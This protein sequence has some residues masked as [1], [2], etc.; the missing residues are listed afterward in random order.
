MIT[1]VIECTECHDLVD[2]T[3][4]SIKLPFVCSSC[5]LEAKQIE[6]DTLKKVLASDVVRD[7]LATNGL[8][9]D[10][11]ALDFYAKMAPSS[12]AAT[13][14]TINAEP[15]EE[16]ATVENTTLL[17]E[18]LEAQVR[19]LKERNVQQANDVDLLNICLDATDHLIVAKDTQ[20][21]AMQRKNEY[22]EK[23]LAPKLRGDI[24][25][26]DT[27]IANQAGTIKN[28]EQRNDD[29]LSRNIF[30]RLAIVELARMVKF[31][32][33]EVGAAENRAG[34]EKAISSGLQS[35]VMSLQREKIDLAEK[36][37]R[38]ED[39]N[40][41]KEFGLNYWNR[42]CEGQGVALKDE[43]AKSLWQCFK[44]RYFDNLTD[45]KGEKAYGK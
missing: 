33:S 9:V 12:V 25:A 18:D 1:T 28:L 42:V 27:Q 15:T 20:I 14:A 19:D 23:T 41:R 30:Q 17:I 37:V 24:D 7:H 3:T 31:L 5:D 22:F 16:F 4:D 26:L 39:E 2:I 44:D 40:K 29:L 36:I 45:P 10:D 34:I 8:R 38:L 11:E 43:K 21:A 32:K 13:A 6:I 35:K